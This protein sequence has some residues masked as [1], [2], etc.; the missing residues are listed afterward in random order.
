MHFPKWT[1][2]TKTLSRLE[3]VFIPPSIALSILLLTIILSGCNN[4][5]HGP[6]I[7]G[8]VDISNNSKGDL[9]FT[10]LF[11]SATI[12]D[13]HTDL[14]HIKMTDLDLLDLNADDEYSKI[15]SIKPLNKKYFILK[16]GE[17]VCLNSD[18][19]E[20]EQIVYSPLNEQDLLV[21][22]GGLDDKKELIISFQKEFKYPFLPK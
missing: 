21:S 15:I 9:C 7:E 13:N 18:N 20:L 3:I 16:N 19:P 22:I 17:T 1:R 5:A 14:K 10:P 12:M 4:P 2:K 8:D 6:P 11:D